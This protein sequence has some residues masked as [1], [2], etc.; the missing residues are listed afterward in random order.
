MDDEL[1]ENQKSQEEVQQSMERLLELLNQVQEIEDDS[2]SLTKIYWRQTEDKSWDFIKISQFGSTFH[3][4]FGRVGGQYKIS[5]IEFRVNDLAFQ[6]WLK[7]EKKI[8]KTYKEEWKFSKIAGKIFCNNENELL[9]KLAAISSCFLMSI[10]GEGYANFDEDPIDNCKNMME[11]PNN[12]FDFHLLTCNKKLL[13]QRLKE[14]EK[15]LPTGFKIYNTED[16]EKY[17]KQYKKE[18][19]VLFEK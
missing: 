12:G 10:I 4:T 19:K 16:F 6:Y 15:I 2:I 3:K 8:D 1:E 18:P 17:E 7:Q 14:I 13:V 5:G 9:N 11:M